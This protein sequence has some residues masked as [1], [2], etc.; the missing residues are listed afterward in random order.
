MLRNFACVSLRHFHREALG[1][2]ARSGTTHESYPWRIPIPRLAGPRCSHPGESDSASSDPAA[3]S[4]GFFKRRVL[5]T[6][7]AIAVKFDI[8][9]YPDQIFVLDFRHCRT[10]S[11]QILRMS[12]GKCC[13]VEELMEARVGIEPT[14]KGFADLSLTTWVPRLGHTV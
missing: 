5:R 10:I 1:P 11:V 9:A 13:F 4:R 8:R 3:F 2:R 14:Y 7:Y 6:E 12:I